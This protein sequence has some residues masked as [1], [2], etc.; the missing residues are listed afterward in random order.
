MNDVEQT[1]FLKK[2]ATDAADAR[3][4]MRGLDEKAAFNFVKQIFDEADV[5]FGVW[6]DSTQLEGIG[7]RTLKGQNQLRDVMALDQARPLHIGVLP[8]IEEGQAIAA[9]H[10]FGDKPH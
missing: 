9:E 10:V 3:E 7:V 4:R 5:V 8:C 2:L 1:G 6:D